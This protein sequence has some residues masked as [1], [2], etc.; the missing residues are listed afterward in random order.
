[1]PLTVGGIADMSKQTGD[2]SG[3][4]IGFMNYAYQKFAFSLGQI[5]GASQQATATTDESATK[6]ASR[7]T[8]ATGDTVTDTVDQTGKGSATVT[9]GT[10]GSAIGSADQT[11]TEQTARTRLNLEGLGLDRDTVIDQRVLSNVTE[12]TKNAIEPLDLDKILAA[13]FA[14]AER[15]AKMY[16]QGKKETCCLPTVI[17]K[18]T[19]Y[20]QVATQDNRQ[21]LE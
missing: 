10:V 7:A 8:A 13:A 11:F 2:E 21:S 20:E 15:G 19:Q 9:G 6:P 12:V 3:K 18:A 14:G 5:A 16:E 4:T 1:M 17:L